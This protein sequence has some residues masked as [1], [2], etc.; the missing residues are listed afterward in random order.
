MDFRPDHQPIIDLR[1]GRSV[2]AE[3]VLVKEPDALLTGDRQLAVA[4]RVLDHM[5]VQLRQWD[6]AGIGP[7]STWFTLRGPELDTDEILDHVRRV[8]DPSSIAADRIKLSIPEPWLAGADADAIGRVRRLAELGVSL[9]IGDF[10]T[11][12]AGVDRLPSLP[13]SFV[14]IGP[15]LARRVGEPGGPALVEAVLDGAR[16]LGPAAEPDRIAQ[17]VDDRSQLEMLARL[18]CTHVQ[19]A[20]VLTLGTTTTAPHAGGTVIGRR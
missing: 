9:G 15:A 13:L 7:A 11:A 20:I 12:G 3:V 10:G 8:L 14:M 1:T 4:G 19:G 18:G 6:D 2:G 17:G 5:V 16:A